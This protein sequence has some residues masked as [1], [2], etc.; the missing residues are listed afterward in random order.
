MDLDDLLF[1]VA[2]GMGGAKCGGRAAEMAVTALREYFRSATV[3]VIDDTGLHS[4]ATAPQEQVAE[5]IRIANDRI[6]HE[7]E[8]N[9]ECHGMGCTLSAIFI[10]GTDAIIGHVG[11]S[12]VYL[13]RDAE[14]VQLTRDDSVVAKLIADGKIAPSDAASHPMRNLLMESVGVEESVNIQLMELPL[15]AGDRLLLSSDGLH[16]VIGDIALSTILAA[17]ESASI[18]AQHLI[19]AAR[20]HGAPDNVSCILVCC[21]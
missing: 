17:T 21:G 13:Y 20:D 7:S 12:R 5:A 15:R 19:Q 3:S 9:P 10:D 16:G 6:F 8:A 14:L 18:T 4:N 1:V 11:D 2:D